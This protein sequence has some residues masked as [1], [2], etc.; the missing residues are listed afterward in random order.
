MVHPYWMWPF[1]K[2]VIGSDAGGRQGAVTELR[3]MEQAEAPCEGLSC[4]LM[5]NLQVLTWFVQDA[6]GHWCIVGTVTMR[7]GQ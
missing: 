7:M 1:A 6:Y 3:G 2:A 4:P 5:S